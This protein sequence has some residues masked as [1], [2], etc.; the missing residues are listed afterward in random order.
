MPFLLGLLSLF[1]SG[2]KGLFGVKQA[3]VDVIKSSVDVLNSGIAN[4]AQKTTAVAQI[5]TAEASSGYWLA[6][7]WRP[8][9]MCIFMVMIISFWFGHSPP[10]LNA[11]MPPMIGRLFDLIEL[12]LG[13]YIPCR[14]LEKIV[15]Q[16][17][18]SSVIKQLIGNK[19]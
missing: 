16:I 14:T 9:F 13:G 5:L 10:Q 11:S 3:Q 17:N 12:G 19:G 8:M 6:A 7:C 1:S 18:L 2:I 4:D 15:S